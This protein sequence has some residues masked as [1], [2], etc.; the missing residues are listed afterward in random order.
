MEGVEKFNGFG[1]GHLG[2][3]GRIDGFEEGVGF[4][5]RFLIGA[6]EGEVDA[7]SF[8]FGGFF[9]PGLEFFQAMRAGA[10]PEG[11]EGGSG[12]G[13]RF[14]TGGWEGGDGM[15]GGGNDAGDGCFFRERE[16][17]R[18]EGGGLA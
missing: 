6:E 16:W 11:D 12:D 7:G 15:T 1:R 14:A 4:V 8:E 13:K 17:G 3:E 9:G 10:A 5:A 2:G 18:M